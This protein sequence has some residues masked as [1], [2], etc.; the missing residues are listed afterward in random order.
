L[1]IGSILVFPALFTAGM[2]LIDTTDSI[3]MVGAYG[4]AFVKPVRK[5]Y[6]NM[7]ITFV[8]VIVAVIVGGIETLALI[9]DKFVLTGVLWDAVGSLSD[10]FGMLGYLIIGI[11]VMSWVVSIGVYRLK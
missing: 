11:F 10:K 4:W 3:L 8:S 1:P 5:L 6:Y 2:I 9:S 7:T